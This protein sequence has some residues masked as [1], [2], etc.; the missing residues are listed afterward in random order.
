M[1]LQISTLAERPHLLGQL[2][3]LDPGWPEFMYHGPVSDAHYGQ[4]TDA[5][6]DFT[7]VATDGARVVARGHSIP[8]A[9]RVPGRGQLPPDGWDRLLIWAFSDLRSGRT[10]DTVSAVEIVIDPARRGQGLSAAVLEAMAE[11]ARGRGFTTLV[12]PLRPTAKQQH[13]DTP[14]GEYA[15]RT[16]PDGLPADPWLRTHV[17]MGGRVVGLAPTS[18]VVPGSLAQWRAWTGLPF[19]RTGPVRV[20]GGLVPVNCSLEHDYGVYVEPNIWVEHDLRAGQ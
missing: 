2:W 20:P 11:N 4:F 12:V 1:D 19:D 3:D 13:P 14:M 17:R 7:I 15:V 9:L 10:P 16:G 5:F 18:M 8:F 6:R